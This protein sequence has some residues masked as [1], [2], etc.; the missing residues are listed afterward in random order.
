MFHFIGKN[1]Y[2]RNS[3]SDWTVLMEWA[4]IDKPDSTNNLM[5]VSGKGNII[6]RMSC[7]IVMG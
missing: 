3:V 5:V 2:L 7:K 6:S 1:I 4:H